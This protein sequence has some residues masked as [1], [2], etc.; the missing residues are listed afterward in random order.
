MPA[1]PGRPHHRDRAE[2]RAE[3]ARLHNALDQA[4]ASWAVH[5]AHKLREDGTPMVFSNT[6]IAEL[7][8][9]ISEQVHNAQFPSRPEH[10]Q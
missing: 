4:M 8:R 9:W 1:A 10:A 2:R 7:S 6:T 3:Y 5:H